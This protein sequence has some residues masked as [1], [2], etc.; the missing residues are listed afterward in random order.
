MKLVSTVVVRNKSRPTVLIVVVKCSFE[1]TF[2]RKFASE[3]KM[4]TTTSESWKS[5]QG[6]RLGSVLRKSMFQNPFP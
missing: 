3:F 1:T 5:V 6:F 2:K 4:Q